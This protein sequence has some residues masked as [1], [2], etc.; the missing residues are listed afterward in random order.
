M[1][2]DHF[3]IRTPELE[4]TKDFFCDVLELTVG[5]RPPFPFP[6]YWLY[7]ADTPIVHLI[8]TDNT[9]EEQTGT[10]DH[11]AFSGDGARFD[12]IAAKLRAESRV[13]RE[14]TVPGMGLRQIFVA[15]PH[16]LVVELNFPPAD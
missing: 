4:A 9:P 7:H 3:S 13:L 11:L 2:L 10:V 5:E 15:G 12:E 1:K 14:Q 6:G 8:A 16:G